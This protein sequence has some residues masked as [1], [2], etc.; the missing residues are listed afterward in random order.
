[1]R[2][3]N[4]VVA[5]HIGR[6]RARLVQ[7][8]EGADAVGLLI[9]LQRPVEVEAVILE[10]K[11]GDIGAEKAVELM[12]VAEHQRPHLRVHAVGAEHEIERRIGAILESDIDLG[13]VLGERRD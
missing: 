2:H 8:I 6:V 11:R 9:E 7:R 10:M 3:V 12:L 1:M 13:V 5:E 4:L